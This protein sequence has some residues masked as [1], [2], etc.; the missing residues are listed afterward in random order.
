MSKYI[1]LEGNKIVFANGVFGLAYK[2]ELPEKYSLGGDD[3]ASLNEY[4]N[5]ALKD[6]P[7][8][9]KRFISTHNTPHITPQTS[10]NLLQ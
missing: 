5:K 7:I 1:Y 10:A 8:N 4:W 2:L 9:H 3:Y 6:L